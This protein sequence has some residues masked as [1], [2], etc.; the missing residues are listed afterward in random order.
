MGFTAIEIKSKLAAL[1]KKGLVSIIGGGR[2]AKA[3]ITAAG[4]AWLEREASC[5]ELETR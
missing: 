4:E 2:A 1:R 3:C 5:T